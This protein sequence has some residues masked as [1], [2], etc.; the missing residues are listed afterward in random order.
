MAIDQDL[1]TELAALLSDIFMVEVDPT[2]LETRLIEDYGVNSMD[3]V[4]V[5]ERLERKY[6]IKVPT[7]DLLKFATFGDVVA[8]VK[9]QVPKAAV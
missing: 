5:G 7:E 1:Q 9:S 8:Y 3:V 4:D 2:Q 6:R